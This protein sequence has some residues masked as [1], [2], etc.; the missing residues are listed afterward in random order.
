MPIFGIRS[1]TDVSLVFCQ[2]EGRHPS[3]HQRTPWCHN[4]LTRRES[5]SRYHNKDFHKIH[6]TQ[7]VL[8]EPAPSS[9]SNSEAITDEVLV[10]GALE[11]FGGPGAGGGGEGSKHHDTR[12]RFSLRPSGSAEVTSRVAGVVKSPSNHLVSSSITSN[13]AL[14]PA[15]VL[16]RCSCLEGDHW[17]CYIYIF[18][19]RFLLPQ[20]NPH[21][22]FGRSTFYSSANIHTVQIL[23][24]WG[25]A[26]FPL[27][28]WHRASYRVHQWPAS[29]RPYSV[30]PCCR[31]IRSI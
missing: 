21:Q 19:S 26:R 27:Y 18:S 1:T 30:L 14:K 6:D 10:S 13:G 5:V 3:S 17:K 7:V 23:L 31:S 12:S 11:M 2:V 9:V 16:K 29:T 20:T 24:P 25:G 28:L 4:H 8:Q 22:T 15:S